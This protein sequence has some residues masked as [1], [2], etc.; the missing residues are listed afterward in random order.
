M[1]RRKNIIT[2]LVSALMLTVLGCLFVGNTYATATTAHFEVSDKYDFSHGGAENN[3]TVGGVEIAEEY[4]SSL[5][6]S[7]SEKEREFMLR[8]SEFSL[9]YSDTV[10]TDKLY[11]SYDSESRVFAVNAAEY[12]YTGSAGSVSWLPKSATLGGIEIPLAEGYGETVL[13]DEALSLLPCTVTY[14]AEISIDAIDMD[15][16]VNL[17][18]NTA[19]YASDSAEYEEAL[20]LYNEYIMA[21]KLYEDSLKKYE[22]YLAQYQEYLDDVEIY[23]AYELAAEK[24]NADYVKYIN[25]LKELDAYGLDVEKYGKYLSDIG[26]VK[27]QLAGIELVK[28]PMTDKRSLY[29]AVMGGTVD[30]VL[31]NESALTGVLGVDPK[32][33]EKAGEATVRVRA[34]MQNYYALKNEE[35]RYNYYI[36]N[37]E[38]FCESFLA[39]TRALDKLYSYP[40]VRGTLIA[41][42]KDRKYIILVAQLALVSNALIDGELRDYDGNVAYDGSW[43]I[44]K[45]TV[46][47]ILENNA[48]YTDT[49]DAKPLACGYPIRMNEPKPP[50]EVSEP[51]LPTKP[52]VPVEPEYV[53][54]PGSEPKSVSLPVLPTPKNSYV[55][56]AFKALTD[57]EKNELSSSY[58]NGICKRHTIPVSGFTYLIQTEVSKCANSENVKITFVSSELEI[59]YEVEIIKGGTAVFEGVIPEKDE[60]EYNSYKFIGWQDKNG[61]PVSLTSL[62]EDA[63][64]YPL[65]EK[66]PKYYNVTW[67]VNGES[68]TERIMSDTVPVCPVSLSF[69]DIGNYRYEFAG[70]DKPIEPVGRDITY[71][72]LIQKLH[73]VGYSGGGATLT[74]DGETVICDASTCMTVD[75]EPI[76]I[77]ELLERIAGKRALILKTYRGELEFSFTDVMEMSRCGVSSLYLDVNHIGCSAVSFC[78][79]ALES[80]GSLSSAKF[81]A[82]V[83]LKHML[84]NVP[85]LRLIAEENDSKTYVKFKCNDSRIDFEL[86]ASKEYILRPVYEI[87]VYKTDGLEL[88]L[89]FTEANPGDVITLDLNYAHGYELQSL[90]VV[91]NTTGENILN[92]DGSFRMPLANVTVRAAAKR[93]TY[94]VTF[95]SGGKIITSAEYTHGDK[96]SAPKAP[97]KESDVNFSY[98]FVGWDNDYSETV[99]SDAIYE[100]IYRATPIP[101]EQD[102][103]EIKLSESVKR[104]LA[105]AG[106]AAAVFVLGGIPC[107]VL[108]IVFAVKRKKRLNEAGKR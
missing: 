104:L 75:R 59:L 103:G 6:D 45:K 86:S 55:S 29:A 21:K 34:L 95:V 85:E 88:S 64:L 38:N 92:N 33:V 41:E 35:E 105:G 91:N 25:Y 98:E 102:D 11:V 106:A 49:D 89:S 13:T 74:D 100:A 90:S 37:Y 99:T 67:V 52:L 56:D 73:I 54:N 77:S 36:V 62:S 3:V 5:S 7:L 57:E 26:I 19:E 18:Y 76:D 10:T 30:E 66:A 24:Y 68:I 82:S 2:L 60:D 97:R 65:F 69:P 28:V 72:A 20:S 47:S 96:L 79:R 81:S 101:K 17:Y 22:K 71:T 108:S 40:K 15:A 107:I 80:D 39:L 93:K 50:D 16:V 23:R 51:I 42:G 70:F 87:S 32:V 63:V 4:L 43:K 46:K 1:R 53:E 61:N 58:T 31:E 78:L 8:Y 12:S 27:H 9:T 94:T 48:Y 84:F 83:S 14:Q 44:E